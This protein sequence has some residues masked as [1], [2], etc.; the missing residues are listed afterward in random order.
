MIKVVHFGKYYYPD[1]GGIES[2][3]STIAE[4]VTAIGHPN[5]VIC[6]SK[7]KCS[8]QENVNGV[9]IIRAAT[10]ILIHS[11]PIGIGYILACMKEGRKADVVHVHYPNMVAALACLFI[12]RRPRVL[13]HW[14][15][16]IVNKGFF[17][18]IVRPLERLL[19]RRADLVV[20]ATMAYARGSAAIAPFLHKVTAFP[21]GV[22]DP[23]RNTKSSNP[24]G[25]FPIEVESRLQ[26]K[27]IILAVG[28]LVPY[29]G[30]DVLIKSA[31]HI[32]PDAFIVIVGDGPLRQNL[33]SVI[34]NE[35]ARDRILLAGKLNGEQL[36]HL[37]Q[38]A[39][40]FCLPSVERSEAFGVVQ[41]EA[42]AYGIPVITTEI[43]GSGVPWVNQDRVSG[44]N[45]PPGDPHRLAGACNEILLSERLHM[46]LSIGARKR[47]LA[48]FSEQVFVERIVS[49]YRRLINGIIQ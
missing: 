29:K 45:V 41:I 4:R 12:G 37:F 43:P 7:S 31:R 28:R 20:P 21:Y 24:L 27:R 40:L 1:R 11:Q 2:V 34:N 42:M 33:E 8:S 13:V 10:N 23:T 49:A 35:S 6:F 44:I 36:A 32:I 46:T 9:N 14:H 25:G 39:S 38:R 5:T 3:T 15:S 17:G 19:L 48:E 47:F 16:D 18:Y 26:G 22:E 30:F